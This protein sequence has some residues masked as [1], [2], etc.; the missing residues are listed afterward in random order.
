MRAET[1]AV[2]DV[3]HSLGFF[4]V[5]TRN[6]KEMAAAVI[7]D[8]DGEAPRDLDQ[9]LRLPGVGLKTAKVVLGVAVD[10]PAGIAV[11]TH[12]NRLSRR[13]GFTTAKESDRISAELEQL[14]D[15][16]LWNG[17]SMRLV[18]HGRRVCSARAPRCGECGLRR[19]CPQI[20][21]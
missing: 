7:R 19:E 8:H 3:I 20:G 21:L 13:L 14:L 4:R 17:F 1:Q 12:V 18:L 2:E 11:D 6:I 16:R 5:K 15:S 9:L 10:I